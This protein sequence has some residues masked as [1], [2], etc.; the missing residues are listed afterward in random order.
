[1]NARRSGQPLL[2]SALAFA[3]QTWQLH[4]Q[5]LWYDEGFTAWLSVQPLVDILARTA[6][7][8]HPPLYYVL[9]HAWI[10][11]AGDSEFALRFPSVIAGVAIVPLMWRLGYKTLGRAGGI[12]AA[13]LVAVSPLWLWY[14]RE[15]RMYTI[16]T[17][18][19]VAS[20]WLLL[21]WLD[22]PSRLRLLSY[23]V[24]TVLAIYTHF[25]AWFIV[26]AHATF[27]TPWLL[28]DRARRH[29][30]IS[31]ASAWTA[32]FLAYLPWLR[33]VLIR[34]EA[35][36]SYWPGSLSPRYVVETMLESW[37]GG[38]TV[39]PMV[40]DHAAFVIGGLAAGG[41]GA[42]CIRW[43]RQRRARRTLILIITWL[44]IPVI[45][46]L[47]ISFGR[48]KYHPRYMMISAPAFVLALTALPAWLFD[49][50]WR[51]RRV[52][53]AILGV[54]VTLVVF[55]FSL[56]ADY[57]L[58]TDPAF[59]KD[60]WRSVAG[61]LERER[62]PDEPI[63]LV[64]GHA[65]PVF[66][67]YYEDNGWVPL[68]DDPTLNITHVLSWDVASQLAE[69]LRGA[70]GVWLVSWQDEVVDPD[71]LV[72]FLIDRAGGKEQS[73][74]PFW[75]ID[76]RHWTFPQP[77][78]VPIQPPMHAK[79]NVNFENEINLV[80][81]EPPE[82]PL[83][84]NERI[85]LTLY[86]T[87]P[88]PTQRDLK[89]SLDVVDTDGFTWG[90][91]DRRPGSYFHPTFRWR[92]NDLRLGRY[93]LQLEPGT[94]PGAYYIDVT[95]YAGETGET[96]DV[97][98]EAGAPQGRRIR[99]GP[100]DV[101]APTTVGAAPQLPTEAW[102]H[103]TSMLSG[104]YLL[105]SQT[106]V[107]S[108]PELTPGVSIPV[109]LWWRAEEA[110][111]EDLL[112]QFGWRRA[113]RL[114]PV[115]EPQ[116]P[117]GKGWPSNTWRAGELVLTKAR[118]KVAPRLDSGQAT[119]TAWLTT[120]EGET[121]PEVTIGEFEIASG[122]KGRNFDA[123]T[124]VYRQTA[125]FGE[126]IEL[127]G[128]DLETTTFTPGDS[129]RI[130]LYWHALGATERP[131]TSFVHLLDA[132]G[133]FIVGEDHQ[134]LDGTRPTDAWV[135]GEYVRDMFLFQVPDTLSAGPY[136]LEVGWYDGSD[137][138]L[139]RLPAIGEGADGTRVLLKSTVRRAE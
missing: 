128:Y 132:A 24:L 83:P 137:P 102:W 87:I 73:T 88:A 3:L 130:T 120:S 93:E 112:L 21:R 135:K 41:I 29:R 14:A 7:D 20:T 34:L 56:F 90:Q 81:W 136:R 36:R 12:I 72:P 103:D 25:F 94:P 1:M 22:R 52:V 106:S 48:P 134:P 105:A 58:Y 2:L 116:H 62:E 64:S 78:H 115:G 70:D 54:S 101:T 74:P 13:L 17:A 133:T 39:Q 138:A 91:L 4:T 125:V 122:S 80:G 18:L 111:A 109:S 66:T 84:A 96:L 131:M 42:L 126:T 45:A 98:D 118:V 49:G 121:S 50:D 92:P 37:T 28:T 6:A 104:V 127:I 30:L 51:L 16:V 124:P 55:G 60:D 99:L 139:P 86:W 76:V 61:L 38:H 100:L 5:S 47:T 123:P 114:L 23:V 15:A 40:A 119:L 107:S 46:L 53:G 129:M 69:R 32:T 10:R 63:F 77:P 113:D 9:L 95:V 67:Y 75:G 59:T 35:D 8:I 31:L 33:S 82:L 11:L 26:A 97:L 85:S 19:V 44:V 43:S 117:G 110:P 65:F 68:P 57:N 27:A 71:Q 79:L 89:V 108:L